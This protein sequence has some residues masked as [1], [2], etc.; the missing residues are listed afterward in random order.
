MLFGDGAGAVV[1]RAV[2]GPSRIGPIRTHADPSGGPLIRLTREEG[3][4]RM[5]GPDVY[6]RAVALM[7]EVTRE[8]VSAAGVSL[9]EIDLFVYHQAN[10]RIIRAVGERLGLD[11]ERVVDYVGRFANTSAA[12]LPI[13]LATAERE[14]RLAP[15]ARVL[16]GAFG[17]GLV[18]GGGV[19]QW[20]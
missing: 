19:L 18:W 13:A 5:N 11:A 16:L 8:A 2:D 12:S 20:R 10:A 3:Q 17:A 14:G 4:V 1:V 6:K 7:A 9:D 15:D